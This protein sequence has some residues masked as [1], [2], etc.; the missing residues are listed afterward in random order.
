MF[1]WKITSYANRYKAALDRRTLSVYSQ[2][3]YTDTYGYKMCARI[4]LAVDG[5]GKGTHASLYFVSRFSR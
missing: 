5:M 3:F 4:Y 2:P 1:V